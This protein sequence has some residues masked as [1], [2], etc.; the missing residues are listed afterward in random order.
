MP[1]KKESKKRKDRKPRAYNFI[2]LD[3]EQYSLTAQQKK[4]CDIY[5]SLSG[6]GTQA[7]IEAGYNVYTSHGNISYHLAA[8]I[9]SENLIKPDISAYITKKLEEFGF[10]DEN[11]K[12]Q[13][14]FLINQFADLKSKGKG[15]DMYYKLKGEYAAEKV[16]HGVNEKIEQALSKLA[17]LLP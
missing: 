7:A 13:H 1:E 14:L 10:S 8:V 9:A 15:I 5:L 12:K 16:E 3:K 17:N 6:N 11:I 4:F 2:G